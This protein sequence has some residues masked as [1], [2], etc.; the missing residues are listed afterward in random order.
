ML[1][2]NRL[3][4]TVTLRASVAI[5]LAFIPHSANAQSTD[6]TYRD[7]NHNGRMDAYENPR[8]S[9]QKRV[10]DLLK[11]MTLEEKVGTMMHGSLPSGDVLGHAGVRYDLPLIERYI[12]T[13]KVTSFITRL[14]VPPSDLA[15]QN[16]AVQRIAEKSRLGIPITIS[17][18]PRN[19]FQAVFG[20]STKGGGFSLWPETLGFAAIG[21]PALVRR[22]GDIAR[23]EYRA[24]GIQMALSPQADLA[25]EPRWPRVTATFGADPLQVSRLAGAYVAGFQ[26][27]DKGLTKDGVAT[28]AKHWVGYGAQPDGFDAHNYYGRVAKL[29]NADFAQHVAAFD[30][31]LAKQTAGIMPT[32]P[33]IA[34]VTLNGKPLEQ[35]GAGF[36]RQLLLDLL[37]T[38]KRFNGFILSDWAITNDCPIECSAPTA[39]RPQTPSAIAMPW[40]VEAL[41]KV[42]RFA[43]GVNAGID[44][45]G[46]VTESKV[47]LEAVKSGKVS[48]RRIDDA[49]RRILLVKFE[50]GLFEN[51]YVDE[52]KAAQIVGSGQNHAQAELAQRR[53]QII[54][55]NRGGLVPVVGP[56][57]VWLYKMDAEEARRR[58][59]TVVAT[60]EEAELAILRVET[61]SEILHPNH[62]FGSR[63]NEGRLDF[64]NGDADYEAINR[65]AAVTRTIVSVN[66][67]RP[68]VLTDIRDKAA[69]LL[70]TFGASDGA[71]LDV[72]VGKA[73]AEGRLPFNLPSSMQAV[74]NQDPAKPD[75]DVKPLYPRGYRGN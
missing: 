68:A 42:D 74:T 27:S 72:L 57:K 3:V 23:M 11:R 14:A 52:A 39:E 46:G 71:V 28:V 29:N 61:P 55:E 43:K 7:L 59:L 58:G 31:V 56:R 35:V 13:D 1:S 20:A 12:N 32:Y 60:P 9:N 73:K 22:F 26:G 33:M 38:K 49:V 63:Q 47:L 69:V 2:S 40:G 30:G 45:F 37:R 24:V 62:F 6:K 16:N 25:T 10:D 15:A 70:V 51:P 21:D 48:V 54:L 66:I 36:N 64:R 50:L 75:D 41:S 8:L 5:C 19:H 44:Q 4:F 17:S 67:D 18:D 34:G 65:A 53:A